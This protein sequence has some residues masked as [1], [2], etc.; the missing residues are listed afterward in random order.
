MP[1]RV[2]AEVAEGEIDVHVLY[3]LE[4]SADSEFSIASGALASLE[5]GVFPSL[6]IEG[7]P[8]EYEP[9]DALRH[10]DAAVEADAVRSERSEL[11]SCAATAEGPHTAPA[12]VHVPTA[13]TL[14]AEETPLLA[15]SLRWTRRVAG[16]AFGLSG[17]P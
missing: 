2:T 10:D 1:S 11:E 15:S 3:R 14:D 9:E 6:A 16:V 8:S 7:D 17:L 4:R 13:G 5:V 12:L